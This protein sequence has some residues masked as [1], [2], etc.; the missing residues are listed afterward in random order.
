MADFTLNSL[1][2]GIIADNDV[3]MKSDTAGG[4]TKVTVQDMKDYMAITSSSFKVVTKQV[5]VNM[6]ATNGLMAT[7]DFSE[8]G[9]AL[10][11][12]TGARSNMGLGLKLCGF[13]IDENAQTAN[14]YFY[15]E[16]S[17]PAIVIFTVIMRKI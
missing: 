6:V 3:I 5:D 17:G 13:W 10:F 16:S 7:I 15:A 8:S 12:I 14:G 11:A 2:S 9:Y 1:S 4:L